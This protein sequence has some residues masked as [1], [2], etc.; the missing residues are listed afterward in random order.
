MTPRTFR[1]FCIAHQR[2]TVADD[3][4]S[5]FSPGERLAFDLYTVIR[6]RK[7]SPIRTV[8]Q[9]V[10]DPIQTQSAIDVVRCRLDALEIAGTCDPD[11]LQEWRSVESTLVAVFELL[12]GTIEDTS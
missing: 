8:L 1:D 9:T 2:S 12:T 3:E 6:D 4:L 7:N 11:F 10:I 5:L